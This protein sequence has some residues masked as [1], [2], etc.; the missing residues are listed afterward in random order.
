MEIGGRRVAYSVRRGHRRTLEIALHPDGRL[1][2]TAPQ[3]A[4]ESRIR[5]AVIRRRDWIRKQLARVEDLRPLPAPRR[6]VGGETHRYLGR[7]YRLRLTRGRVDAV[8]LTG[9]FLHVVTGAPRNPSRVRRA[10]EAWYERRAHVVLGERLVECVA[11]A[12]TARLPSPSL[13]IRKMV[14]RWGSCTPSGRIILNVELVKTPTACI[15][16]VIT[17]E[18]CHLKAM[19][20]GREF[21]R[22]LTRL[23]PDW[24]ARRRVLDRQDV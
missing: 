3:E 14:R 22:M 17:H 13:L 15:D 6:Y 21:R 19:S 9:P 1:V 11:R 23:M 8:R 7:Q 16:Y 5:T 4:A 20:H 24:E 2:V 18:L 10:L 12:R